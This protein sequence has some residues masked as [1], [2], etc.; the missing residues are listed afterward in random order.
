MP[1]QSTPDPAVPPCPNCG[2]PRTFYVLK[3]PKYA[4]RRLY[5]CKPCKVRADAASHQRHRAERNARNSA[6]Y[7]SNRERWTAYW[8]ERYAADPSKK[9]AAAIRYYADHREQAYSSAKRW[10]ASH[11]E[12]AN[13]SAQASRIVQVAIRDGVLTRPDT[14]ESCGVSGGKIEAAHS[15]YSRPLDVRW[16]CRSCHRRWDHAEPKTL[17]EG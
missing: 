1:D 15:D 3:A 4:G 11:P 8:R 6:Y 10:N 7:A 17:K 16:L 14:C 12:R 13:Q 5:V 2:G 9:R